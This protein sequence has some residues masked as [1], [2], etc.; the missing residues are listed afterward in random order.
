MDKKIWAFGDS[1]TQS[2]EPVSGL[3]DYRFKYKQYKGR[4]PKVF[5]DFLKEDYGYE[6]YNGGLGGADNYTILDL[7]INQLD[8]IEDDDI[9]IIGWSSVERTRLSNKFGLFT[10]VHSHWEE[11]QKK[12][13]CEL[14]GVSSNTIDEILVNRYD[15]SCYVG[16]LN[17]IIKLLNKT[18]KNN[19]LIH[20]SPFNRNF[21]EMNV[22]P[23]PSNIQTIWQE[24]EGKVRDNHYSE[25]GHKVISEYFYKII[26]DEIKK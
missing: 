7:I 21:K 18:F 23:V 9:I 11:Q 4:S 10:P 3:S 25:N 16:E 24:T 6:C 8:Q 22:T 5:S 14:I 13:N 17:R 15:S 26:N 2:L 12:D 20:W 19:I 1:H